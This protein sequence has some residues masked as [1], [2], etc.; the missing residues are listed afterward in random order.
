MNFEI[1]RQYTV[2]INGYEGTHNV[3]VIGINPIGEDIFLVL[4]FLDDTNNVE[5]LTVKVSAITSW[6]RFSNAA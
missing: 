5:P 3:E 4:K 2:T 6:R 1:N